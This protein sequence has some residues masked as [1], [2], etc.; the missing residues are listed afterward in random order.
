MPRNPRVSA[1]GLVIITIQ[2]KQA[3]SVSPCL[4]VPVTLHIRGISLDWFLLQYR[5]PVMRTF[6]AAAVVGLS[7]LPTVIAWGAAGTFC[8][9]SPNPPHLAYLPPSPTN[10]KKKG[11]EIVATLAQ[12]HL[13]PRALNAVC[14]ILGSDGNVNADAPCYLATVATWADKIRFR[15]HWS[16]PL[17]YAEG[18]SDHPPDNCQFPGADGWA[19]AELAN[20]LDAIHN[21][22]SILTDFTSGSLAS[23]FMADDGGSGAAEEALKFLIH[24]VGDM[25][26]PLHLCGRDKGGNGDKVHWDGRVTSCVLSPCGGV[27]LC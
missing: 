20:V 18:V 27:D 23:S 7:S 12:S 26:Q 1:V 2:L 3:P 13:D 9:T 4:A 10:L 6:V 15:A 16:A 25:H 19:G 11:H 21:V 17:H 8:P 5:M 24:F 22:S 14:S